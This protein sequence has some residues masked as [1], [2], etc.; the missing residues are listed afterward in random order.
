MAP[1]V[2]GSTRDG[3][4]SSLPPQMQATEKTVITLYAAT[5]A[6]GQKATIALEE[7]ELPYEL[8]N[9]VLPQQEHLSEQFL[10][11][12][13]VGRIPALIDSQHDVTVYGTMPI[14]MYLAERCN[15]LLPATLKGRATVYDRA[16]FISSDLAPAFAGQFIFSAIV[17]P[18]QPDTV[19]Y[20][21]ALVHRMVAVMDTYL[22]A[23]E[24]IAG[25]EYTIA[26]ILGY[27][28]A[29]TSLTRMPG[30]IDQYP[31]VKRWSAQVGARPA[32][33]KGMAACTPAG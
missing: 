1:I 16:A 30:A 28:M 23:S 9:L 13:P 14:A 7:C 24:Y 32:V 15:R 21:E 33:I 18:P 11:I 4:V 8:H 22:A 29:A 26:D 3:L 31:N 10:K 17:K 19:A 5:T 12:N 20:Y 2:A 25:D 27:P 6:N